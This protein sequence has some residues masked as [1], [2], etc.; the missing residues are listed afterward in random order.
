M[1]SRLAIIALITSLHA[2]LCQAQESGGQAV[3]A[4]VAPSVFVVEARGGNDSAVGLGTAFLASVEGTTWLVTA[5]H[6][7][8][9]A[10][11]VVL[12][13][14]PVTLPCSV[15][16]VNSSIDLAVL[17]PAGE[18]NSAPLRLADTLPAPGTA[19]F[20]VGNPLGLE[21]SISQ[22]LITTKR[23]IDGRVLAQMSAQM[24][25]GSS[26]GPVVQGDA[27]NFTRWHSPFNGSPR[28]LRPATRQYL[29]RILRPK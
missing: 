22:G 6:V 8:A 16:K 25:P 28:T 18:L 7:V 3:Y 20:V 29:A 1:A 13:V 26:G 4:A 15:A 10:E 27:W 24:S 2:P 5:A 11:S 14:G 9:G 12:R 17:T 21:R 19:I 23:E